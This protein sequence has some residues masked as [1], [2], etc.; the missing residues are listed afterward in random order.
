MADFTIDATGVTVETLDERIA[1]LEAKLREPANFGPDFSLD[2][3]TPIP[4]LVR[5]FAAEIVELQNKVKAAVDATIPGAARGVHADNIGAI[6][7]TTR[8]A[9][10]ASTIPVTYTG[11][12]SATIPSGLQFRHTAT[13]TLWSSTEAVVL[14]GGGTGTTTLTADETGPIDVPASSGW[15]IVI[16]DADLTSIASTAESTQ[17]R[18]QETDVD[19]EERRKATVSIIGTATVGAVRAELTNELTA[20]GAV[21][22]QVYH[23]PSNSIDAAGREP[24]TV[25]VVVEDNGVIDD[26]IIANKIWAV[27][28]AGIDTHGAVSGTATDSEGGTHTIRFT[29]I[30]SVDVHLRITVSTA[31][32][33]VDIVDQTS[34][35][36]VIRDEVVR[37]GKLLPPGRD[38]IPPLFASATM[39]SIPFGQATSVTCEQSTDGL[40]WLTTTLAISDY[41]TSAFSTARVTVNYTS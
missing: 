5:I 15:E 39:T 27:V 13:D 16:G 23:N 30:S 28:P 19:Y 20:L 25:E 24:H 38:V 3:T 11:T 9:A 34:L 35:S 12:A 18:N 1:K 2:P 10:T 32:A 8:Y 21:S 31:G 22:V 41:E 17:G 4:M 6:T 33:E 7:N 36:S 26:N 37:V 14:S 29:R 40:S